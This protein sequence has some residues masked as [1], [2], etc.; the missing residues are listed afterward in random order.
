MTVTRNRLGNA[1]NPYQGDFKRVLCVCSAGLLRS[2]TLAWVLSQD[3]YN[4]NTRAVGWNGDF[5]LIPI[6]EA[7][8]TWADQIVF[9]EPSV[10][11]GVRSITQDLYIDGKELITLNIPDNFEYRNPKLVEIIK[12]Q[13]AQ[14]IEALAA[15]AVP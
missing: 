4:Y 9:V 8:I 3:P 14:A 11:R 10:E 1:T 7:H 5:A 13:Y 2:P 15:D 6:D 12:A